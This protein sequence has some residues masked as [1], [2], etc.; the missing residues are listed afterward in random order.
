[1]V[2][3]LTIRCLLV[4]SRFFHGGWKRAKV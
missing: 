2:A 3:D 1:M 4:S